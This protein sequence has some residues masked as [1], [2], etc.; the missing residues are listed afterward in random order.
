MSESLIVREDKK[1]AEF[2]LCLIRNLLTSYISSDVIWMAVNTAAKETGIDSSKVK[3]LLKDIT[4]ERNKDT[5]LSQ[6][7]GA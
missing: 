2:L 5:L 6:M 7:L 1:E 3:K 4:E